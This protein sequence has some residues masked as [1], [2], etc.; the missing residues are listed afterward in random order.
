VFE[1][2]AVADDGSEQSQ[3]GFAFAASLAARVG[4]RV[5]VASAID[6]PEDLLASISEPMPGLDR[7]LETRERECAQALSALADTAPEGTAIDTR[8]LHGK[9]VPAVLELLDEIR[10]D[11]V[12][13]GTS[14]VGF[15]RY[16]LGSVSQRL[17]ESAPCDLLLF[18]G[19]D[20]PEEPV[21]VIAAVDGSQAARRGVA[22]AG[23]LA[24]GLR[25]RLILVHV[26]DDALPFAEEPDEAAHTAARE[27]GARLLRDARDSI[28][29]P[30]GEVLE[31]L[32][33]GHPREELIAACDE[34]A[35]AVAVIGSRGVGGF[36]GLL[37]GSMAR[38]LVNHAECPVLVT[39]AA[40]A[41]D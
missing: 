10:P 13:A 20:V 35:A 21:T 34:R 39:R 37:V 16:V 1:H 7:L 30:V 9:P 8:V 31:E 28:A 18:R 14:G 5:T 17:L 6:W 15:A 4:A 22:V 32:R 23:E 38:D 29:A 41:A 25:A 40:P 2:I 33:E 24:A 11:L 26:V 12:V 36:H 3:A 19:P 27:H